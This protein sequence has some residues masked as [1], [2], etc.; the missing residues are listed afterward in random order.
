MTTGR[1]AIAAHELLHSLSDPFVRAQPPN[2]C[3]DESHVCDGRVDI[4]A[5]DPFS[6]PKLSQRLLDLNHDDYY[7][8]ADPRWDVQ[9]SAWLWQLDQP[10]GQLTTHVDGDAGGSVRIGTDA[11][12]ATTCTYRAGFSIVPVRR[13]GARG[14]RLRGVDG[15]VRE[16]RSRPR[17]PVRRSA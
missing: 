15:Q 8:H 10:S 14:Q 4:L 2:A 7:A 1:R 16:R 9:D 17:G 5:T 6:P 3:P 11:V 13:G 12:C